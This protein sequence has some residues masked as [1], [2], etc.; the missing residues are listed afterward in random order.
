MKL[1]SRKSF[2]F[3]G[4]PTHWL[5]EGWGIQDYLLGL[6]LGTGALIAVYGAYKM[7]LFGGNAQNV[8]GNFAEIQAALHQVA[9]SGNYAGV[10]N[11]TLISAGA[12]PSNIPTDGSSLLY[13]PTNSAG[14]QSQYTVT[15]AVGSATIALTPV[16]ASVCAQAVAQLISGG[17]WIS[18]NGENVST[19]LAG[20]T[21]TSIAV[22]AQSLCPA[23]TGDSITA[24]SQ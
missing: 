24:V 23:G 7:G 14:A 12:I 9:P 21:T 4:K 10:K 16:D 22:T 8:T 13:G 15:G 6:A 19:I 1:S 11:D 17:S 3:F 2:S 20:G 18:V 5:E